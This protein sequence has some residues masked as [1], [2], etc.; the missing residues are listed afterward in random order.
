[1]GGGV[2]GMGVL[3]GVASVGSQPFRAMEAVVLVFLVAPAGGAVLG[4]FE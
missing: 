4:V 3:R 2:T 1:M